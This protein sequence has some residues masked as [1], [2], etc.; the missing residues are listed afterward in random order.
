MQIDPHE[1]RMSQRLLKARLNSMDISELI[2]LCKG[3]LADGSVNLKEADF[4][5]NWLEEYKDVIDI[6]PADVLYRTLS[7]VLEDGVLDDEERD[8]LIEL[9]TEITGGPISVMF[10]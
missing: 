2:G 8:E 5:F 7:K 1:Q 9:L 10:Y 6:W 3:V 4:I